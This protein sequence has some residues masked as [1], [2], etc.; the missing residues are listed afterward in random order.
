VGEEN[1][2]LTNKEVVVA[3][4]RVVA[5]FAV[6]RITAD[7]D[8]LSAGA[9]YEHEGASAALRHATAEVWQRVVEENSLPLRG[10]REVAYGDVC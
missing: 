5:P 2:D 4:V 9:V 8:G 10:Q 1:P 3:F 6:S 7:G